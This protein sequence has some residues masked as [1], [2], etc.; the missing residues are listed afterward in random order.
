MAEEPT[1]FKIGDNVHIRGDY[2]PGHIR[3]PYYIRG[4]SERAKGHYDEP[5]Q[6]L[7]RVRFMQTDAWPDYSGSPEDTIDIEIFQHWLEAV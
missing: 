7:Y 4:K 1:H 3:T 6:P 5:Q 2:P